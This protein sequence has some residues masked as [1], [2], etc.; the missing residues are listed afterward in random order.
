[1][2]LPPATFNYS[3]F[4]PNLQKQLVSC[5][6]LS[7][8][9]DVHSWPVFLEKSVVCEATC[10]ILQQ[11]LWFLKLLHLHWRLNDT[12]WL[13]RSRNYISHIVCTVE[14]TIWNTI[15][16]LP[17]KLWNAKENKGARTKQILK[18]RLDTLP[19]VGWISPM[20]AITYVYDHEAAS[21]TLQ[22]IL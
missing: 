7:N 9:M 3:S 21:A 12:K 1:M 16:K 2:N 18:L 14:S 13:D 22:G 20:K 5:F 6:C 8:L 4:H 19:T 10:A 11:Q 15:R 17:T